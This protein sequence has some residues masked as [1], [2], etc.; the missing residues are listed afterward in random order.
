V[1]VTVHQLDRVLEGE[2][3]ELTEALG[4]EER[5]LALESAAV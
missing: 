4:A 3:D 5:R 2:L 1:K